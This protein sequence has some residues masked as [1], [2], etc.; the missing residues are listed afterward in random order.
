M[1]G[2]LRA[3]AGFHGCGPQVFLGWIAAQTERGWTLHPDPNGW[4]GTGIEVVTWHAA[5]GREWPITVVAGLDQKLAEKP[6]T[7][8]AEF[9]SFADLDDVLRHAGLGWLPCFA[10]PEK[11]AVFADAR[12]PDEERSA[13]RALYVAL[14]R[15]RDRLILALPAEPSKEKDRPERMVD[16]LRARTGLAP[17]R[18][19]SR[20]AGRSSRFVCFTRRESG[21]SPT[22]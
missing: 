22:C 3:A 16:L 15:A 2:D 19:A 8:R 4:S 17:G 14:T 1:E 6:G 9:D 12:I 5:K 11:Q 10:A 13:A 7:L 21:S 18:P 20:S